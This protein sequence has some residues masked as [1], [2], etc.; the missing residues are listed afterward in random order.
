M[1]GSFAHFPVLL[2]ISQRA[3]TKNIRLLQQ[4]GYIDDH[5]M[6][7]KIILCLRSF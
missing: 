3:I 4:I 7:T 5:G 2:F 6:A 1:N